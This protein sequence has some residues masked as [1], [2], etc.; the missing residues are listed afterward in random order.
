MTNK[1]QFAIFQNSKLNIP[2]F[3]NWSLKFG[4]YLFFGIWV[5]VL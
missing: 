2:E 1:F 4:F 5:L 3:G